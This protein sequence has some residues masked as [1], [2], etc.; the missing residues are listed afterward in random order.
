MRKIITI[1]FILL[2]VSVKSQNNI[3]TTYFGSSANRLYFDEASVFQIKYERNRSSRISFQTGIRSHSEI[4]HD[5]IETSKYVRYAYNSKKI[6]ATLL[7]SPI[8]TERFSLKAGLGFDVG[9]SNYYWNW[10]GIIDN[11][12]TVNENNEIVRMNFYYWRY[13][14]WEKVDFGV[15]F[16]LQGNYFFNNNLFASAQILFN[17]VFDKVVELPIDTGGQLVRESPLCLSFGLG[18]RF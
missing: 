18:Y 6:D 12:K 10:E 4:Q 9:V 11:K 3:V 16:V 13:S 7:F 17:P 8:S 14:I 5:M 1:V 15:H 2:A